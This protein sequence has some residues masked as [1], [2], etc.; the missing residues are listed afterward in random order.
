M[1][2]KD[3]T[4]SIDGLRERMKGRLQEWSTL[5]VR[6][7]PRKPGLIFGPGQREY[8]RLSAAAPPDGG[9]GVLSTFE[10]W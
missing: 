5:E 6:F 8:P 2:P 9:T 1:R 3:I 4:W 7:R 10:G